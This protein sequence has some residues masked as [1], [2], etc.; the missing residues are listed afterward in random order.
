MGRASSTLGKVKNF[1]GNVSVNG[2]ML[3][4]AVWVH[5]A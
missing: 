2:R 3:K 1:V 4:C 5:R